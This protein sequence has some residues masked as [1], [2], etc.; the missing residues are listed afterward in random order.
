VS[1]P[2]P[3]YRRL[4]LGTAAATF[5]L[6]V[7]GGVVRVSDSGLG[8][9]PAHSGLKGW[10]L[11]QGDVVP[12]VD[13]NTVIEYCHRAVAGA[14]TLMVFGLCFL[15]WRR[16]R[17]HRA[18]LAVTSAAAGLIVAQALLGAATVEHDLDETLVASHLG[19]AMLLLGLLLYAWHASPQSRVPSPEGAG[20]GLRMLAVGASAAVLCTIVAG[21]YMAGTEGRGRLHEGAGAHH[22]CGTQFPACNDDFMPFGQSRLVN[23][24]LAHRAFMYLAV[25][26]L[27]GLVVAVLRRRPGQGLERLAAAIVGLLSLQVLLG[28]LNVWIATEYELLILAHLAVG[29]LLWATS[30]GLAMRLFRV[31]EPAGERPA[32]STAEAVTA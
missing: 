24:H 3:G 19:I 2:S 1:S 12:G 13:L 27:L 17:R 21:G 15:T 26:L 18:L 4:A 22:A 9:G 30:A 8:C 28:A 7:L 16:Y 6:I 25:L 23:I 20:P 14:L 10:P 31:P 5:L 11:C 32:R 29:T